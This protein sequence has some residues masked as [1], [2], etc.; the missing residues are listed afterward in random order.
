MA[1]QTRHLGVSIDRPAPEV[2][3]YV[4]DPGN[5]I[6]WAPGLGSSV[7]EVDGRWFVQMGADR[8]EFAFAP[9]NEFGV[10]DHR[11]TMPSG[12]V[13]DNPMRVIANGPDRCDVVFTV[14]RLPG[15]SDAEFDRDTGLVSADLAHLKEIVERRA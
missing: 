15:L 1:D 2:Y 12:Q 11:V 4:V 14:R 7:E 5:L 10:L 8:V 13:F 3:E 9:R 6:E